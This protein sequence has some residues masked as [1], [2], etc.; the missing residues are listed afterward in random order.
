M[1]TVT[2]AREAMATRFEL[3]LHG[4][5]AMRLRAAG[6][7][8]LAEV[9]RL[10]QQLSPYRPGS[11]IAQLNARAA[12]Q[13]VPVSPDVFA[14][15]QHA[16]Q[17]S[18]ATEGA[19]DITIGPLVRCWGFRKAGNVF[20][21]PAGP[22]G[23][24]DPEFRKRPVEPESH[25]PSEEEINAARAVV[26]MDK[27]Q[28]DDQ[29]RTIRFAAPG[30]RLDLGAIGKGYAVERGAAILREAGVTRAL[31]H[32]GTSTV[33]AIG[34]PPDAGA[35]KIAV[36]IPVPAGGNGSARQEFLLRDESLSVSTVWG[37]MVAAAGRRFGHVIDPRTGHPVQD[38]V[39]AAVVLPGATET[40]ALS[41]ALLALGMTGH[42][43]ISTGRPGLRTLVVNA[44]RRSYFSS[45]AR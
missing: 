9:E 33:C 40:D 24:A 39:L 31:F 16:A 11:E 12:A 41:T 42:A 17:L 32:G 20:S 7:E 28:F 44:D 15:L 22:V 36:E 21:P 35:W 25:L 6:E 38:T 19:F 29:A 26:G 37:R 34:Q 2:L 45:V 13:P 10:E 18:A 1:Q 14:L 30:V 5:N 4:E 27:V 8:A 23:N 3:V 43:K